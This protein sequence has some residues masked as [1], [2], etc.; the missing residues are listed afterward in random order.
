MYFTKTKIY[1]TEYYRRA[2]RKTL[3]EVVKH[4]VIK[5]KR[6][7]AKILNIIFEK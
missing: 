2:V 5:H 7:N 4:A 6:L 1:L 3:K